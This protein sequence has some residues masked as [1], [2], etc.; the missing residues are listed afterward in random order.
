[1]SNMSAQYNIGRPVEKIKERL[2]G[3]AWNNIL[4]PTANVKI[5]LLFMYL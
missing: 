4:L 5:C 2:I 1:M 3:L